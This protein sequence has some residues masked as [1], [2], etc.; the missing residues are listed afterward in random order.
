MDIPVFNVHDLILL[1]T[2]V[3]CV[4]LSLLQPIPSGSNP[5]SHRLLRVFFLCVAVGAACTLLLWSEY[6]QLH[7]QTQLLLPYFLTTAV[8]AKGPILYLY[9]KTLTEESF[10]LSRAHAWHLLPI[11]GIV[12][13]LAIFSVDTVTLRFL[14]PDMSLPMQ[15]FIN[16]LWFTIK[17]IPIIY[18]V[19]AF[20]STC[21]Y[22]RRLEDHYS[23]VTT[24]APFWLRS[25]TLGFTIAWGWIM[26]S[27]VLGHI[28]ALPQARLIGI[29][30]NYITW[31][32]VVA[33]FSYNVTYAHH[34]VTADLDPGSRI[35][36]DKPSSVTVEKILRGIEIDKLYLKKNINIEEFSKKIDVPYR[37][38]SVVIN[39]HFG[40][41]FFEFINMHR[42]EEA[43]RMLSSKKFNRL[44]I[45]DI[46]LESGFNS[47][48]AFQRFF[49]RL[50]GMSPS[51]YRKVSQAQVGELMP[52]GG[53]QSGS[54]EY[55][56]AENS[57]E[58]SLVS[59]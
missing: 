46:L 6:I 35:R 18:S 20:R 13:A 28:L 19:A 15:R 26:V 50:V 37:E 40:T 24:A 29:S 48:S 41:N 42:V 9:V 44:T 51:N 27:N 23:D 34:L 31:G 58:K 2:V 12:L 4:I 3:I 33:L 49:K 59:C 43:K 17:T 52:D 32:L 16:F 22:Q 56:T 11:G 21:R 30:E 39:K 53:E 14:V 36:N 25:L 47:K 5:L 8:L 7:R 38:V 57:E 55:K 54:G 1:M 45:L 10:A